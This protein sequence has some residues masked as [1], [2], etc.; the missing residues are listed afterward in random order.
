MKLRNL[1]KIV[2]DRLDKTSKVLTSK[3]GRKAARAAIHAGIKEQH[4][5]N[6][7]AARAASANKTDP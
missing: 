2:Q 1:S 5:K 7:A 4:R 3:L 6:R